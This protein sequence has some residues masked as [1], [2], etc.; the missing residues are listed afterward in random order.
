MGSPATAPWP[1]VAAPTPT[2]RGRGQLHRRRRVAAEAP[3]LGPLCNRP[4][5]PD[6]ETAV[7]SR[8]PSTELRSASPARAAAETALRARATGLG[9]LSGDWALRSWDREMDVLL[10]PTVASKRTCRRPDCGSH[11][12]R[13]AFSLRG[14]TRGGLRQE[15][16]APRH[17]HSGRRQASASLSCDGH[18]PVTRRRQ[19]LPATLDLI[20]DGAQA[21]DHHQ[22]GSIWGPNPCDSLH[23]DTYLSS[24]IQGTESPETW[25]EQ[26]WYCVEG[27]CSPL[28][29]PSPNI[30]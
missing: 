7:P 16:T 20:A 10:P 6:T 30:A 12:G 9:R 8:R 13:P 2:A 5:R 21:L 18:G 22:R 14:T 28:T 24:G 1:P 26:L 3:S 17:L 27:G 11:W 23:Q 15:L 25:I 4:R 19:F 29:L